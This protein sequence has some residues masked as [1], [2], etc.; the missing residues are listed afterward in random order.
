MN[1]KF[2][3]IGVIGLTAIVII[4]VFLSSTGG[5]VKA[6]D[7]QGP[8]PAPTATIGPPVPPNPFDGPFLD[9]PLTQEEALELV[10]Q[11]DKQDSTWEESWS[12]DDLNSGSKRIT[13]QSYP[14]RGYDGSEYGPGAED[15]PVWVITIAG[16]LKWNGFHGDDQSHD[17]I[18]Y[19]IAQRTGH[20]LRVAVGPYK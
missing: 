8:T 4:F 17:G 20:L 11:L 3:I 2:L 16:T 7:F 18:T 15:G 5:I 6:E 14:N 13:V 1:R 10:A 9:K 19:V 12:I